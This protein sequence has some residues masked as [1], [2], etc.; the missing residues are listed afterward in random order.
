MLFVILVL[1]TYFAHNNKLNDS[2]ST[3]DLEL[4]MLGSLSESE[5][6][7]GSIDDLIFVLIKALGEKFESTM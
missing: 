4:L 5:K 2:E 6:E 1:T 3:A 7:I